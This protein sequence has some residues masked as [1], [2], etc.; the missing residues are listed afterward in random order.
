MINLYELI[1]AYDACGVLS[2]GNERDTS[3]VVMRTPQVDVL[4]TEMSTGSRAKYI[5]T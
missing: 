3:S 1:A 5:G 4:L 2:T